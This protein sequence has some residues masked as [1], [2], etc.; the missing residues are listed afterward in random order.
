MLAAFLYRQCRPEQIGLMPGRFGPMPFPHDLDDDRR[1]LLGAAALPLPSSRSEFADEVQRQ[2]A[3]QVLGQF[4]L[5]LAQMRVKYPRDC[6]FSRGARKAMISIEVRSDSSEPDDLHAGRR[7]MTL[8][9]DLPR[10]AYATIVI[11]RLTAGLEP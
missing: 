5:T 9:F 10:G 11:K 2:L 4:G 1:A 6:F 3:E 7:K 8:N